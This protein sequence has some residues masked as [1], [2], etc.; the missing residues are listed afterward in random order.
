MDKFSHII[1][2]IKNKVG[3]ANKKSG[4]V[5]VSGGIDSAVCLHLTACA[6]GKEH[7]YPI[8]M[9]HRNEH[10]Q[11]EPIIRKMCKNL[12]V[13]LKK[14][15]L[16]KIIEVFIEQT[17]CSSE[18]LIGNFAARMRMAYLYQY[19]A[20]TDSLVINTGNLTEIK[21][22]Y[23]T[24]WGDQAGDISPIGNLYKTEVKNLA[25]ELG[26]PDDIVNAVPSA[27]FFV[28]QTDEGELGMSYEDLDNVLIAINKKQCNSIESDVINHVKTLIE[29][30]EHK[31][32]LPLSPQRS[33]N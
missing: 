12:G 32:S 19:A 18:L 1:N 24:K 33:F 6:L 27:G 3:N 10:A 11:Y 5:G 7:V 21:T 28:E 15:D 22:G 13:Q 29:S 31:R 16:S 14:Y 26:V 25:V 23:C 8:F 9:P 17:G 2:F 20:D 30:S 4:V